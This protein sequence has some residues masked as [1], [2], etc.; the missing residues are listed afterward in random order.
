MGYPSKRR[1]DP[2]ATVCKPRTIRN[3]P[4]F[5]PCTRL[6][7]LAI[8][9]ILMSV[10]WRGIIIL[11]FLFM[12]LAIFV[13]IFHVRQPESAREQTLSKDINLLER[14]SLPSTT[15]IGIGIVGICIFRLR[16][17]SIHT[18]PQQ[19]THLSIRC[20]NHEVRTVHRLRAWQE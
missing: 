17:S 8:T 7:L 3:F 13:G 2:G 11:T 18:M 10:Q 19:V 9:A 15:N 4:G 6:R 5:S 20:L 14:S 12:L 16:D 1:R